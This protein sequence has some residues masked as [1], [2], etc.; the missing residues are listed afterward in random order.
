MGIIFN[1]DLFVVYLNHVC[2]FVCDTLSLCEE[3]VWSQHRSNRHM[4]AAPPCLSVTEQQ[5][6]VGV[7]SC[8]TALSNPPAWSL[9][10]FVRV[11]NSSYLNCVFQVR[12]QTQPKAAQYV[13]YTG[14]Y[15][16]LRKT[17]SKEVSAFCRTVTGHSHAALFS[18]CD[19]ST[20]V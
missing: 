15:D 6:L 14:T 11:C 1:P 17:V 12:L 8:L 7:S 9:C 20:E 2:V 13:L 18:T 16:C 10:V 19:T 4:S 5:M 3:T